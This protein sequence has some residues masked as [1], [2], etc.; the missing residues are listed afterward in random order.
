MASKKHNPY[1][2]ETVRQ[3]RQFP[4]GGAI[5][6]GVIVIIQILLIVFAFLYNP[7]PQ[8]V[9]REYEILVT[10]Q[11]NGSLII[12]YRIVWTPLDESEPLTWIDIG[13]PNHHFTIDR[14]TLSENIRKA[15]ENSDGDYVSAQLD[16]DRPY[17]AGETLELSFR[18]YQERMLCEDENGFFYSLIPGW[19]NSTPVE[20]YSFRWKESDGI[21]DTNAT[22]HR[23]SEYIWE[24]KMDCGDYVPMRIDYA[25]DAF[26][27]VRTE[28]YVP[29][30]S[31]GAYDELQ[32]SKIALMVVLIGA[33]VLLLIAE[34]YIIDSFVSYHRGRGF[35]MGYGYH[36]HTYGRV[37]PRYK[38]ESAKRSASAGRG[39][40]GGGC[41]CACA[42]ACA[43]GGRAGCS[44]KDTYVPQ[45]R[46]RLQIPR[47]LR[48]GKGILK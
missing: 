48:D 30:D 26:K 47:E 38:T 16:L 45:N 15:T 37:N 34:V 9:I 28:E 25:P 27:N 40:S 8:D 21:T 10:P 35:L 31:S 4:I 32:G 5:G 29:F 3:K 12:D 17:H 14:N 7:Q 2:E 46:F 19:F 33:A 1:S 36:V 22:A 23:Y 18:I 42:C 6:I 13:M 41:A 11:K 43:G 39:H 20:Y 24:G 44:Q